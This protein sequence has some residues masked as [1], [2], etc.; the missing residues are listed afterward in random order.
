MGKLGF[1]MMRLPLKSDDVTD[2]DYEEL[3]AMV[4]RFLEAGFT[5]FDTSAA[6][7][8]GKSEEA[9]RKSIVERHPRDSFTIATKFPT[10][11]LVPED[12][13]E[14]TFQAQLDNLGVEYI[15]Y[16]LMHDIQTVFYEG[17]G[18]EDG[19]IPKTHLF[20]HMKEWK[21][22]GRIKHL[23]ISFHASAELLDRLLTEHPEVEFVQLAINPIDW[24]SELV[25]AAKCYEVVRRHGLPVVGM[26]MVKGGGLSTLPE[27]AEQLLRSYRPADSMTSWSLRFS[28]DL[29][30]TIAIL[31]GMSNMEQ[32]EDNIRTAQADKRF[33]KEEK[34]AFWRAM[35][36]YRNSAPITPHMMKSFIGLTWNGVPTTAILQAYSICQIQPDP[37][38]SDDNNYFRGALADAGID[39]H[40]DVP[41]PRTILPDGTDETEL[42]NKAA[43]WLIEN[44]FF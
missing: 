23:G 42:V 10:F 40:G 36:I 44:S 31:S 3:N 43:D 29:E 20:E 1:G 28:L 4:D 15:D 8:A 17:V 27:E 22:Q 16:Y 9:A 25:Q 26:E 30:D 37:G 18:G 35:D 14:E 38:F 12:K 2:F 11:N 6:Y 41:H 34:L 21:A 19:I 7:H 5:Y 32:M 39:M 13:V 24:D 33:S